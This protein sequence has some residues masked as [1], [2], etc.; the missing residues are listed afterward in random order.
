MRRDTAGVVGRRDLAE[1]IAAHLLDDV[2]AASQVLRQPAD[3][4]GD[5]VV[6]GLRALAAA[7]HQQPQPA[8]R[9]GQGIGPAADG[10]DR[11]AYRVADDRRLGAVGGGKALDLGEAGGDGLGPGGQEPVG[12]AEHRVLLVQHHAQAGQAAGQGC[13]HGGIAAEADDRVG[14]E[15]L[16][17][18]AGLHEPDRQAEQSLE[19]LERTAAGDAA[20]ADPMDRHLAQVRAEACAAPVGDELH[21]AAAGEKLA[22]QG[23]GGEHVPARAPR[24]QHHLGRPGRAHT[25]PPEPTR[26]R[27]RPSTMPMASETASS[28]EPP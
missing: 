14:A 15:A 6:E 25:S 13:R 20:G 19:P 18:A 11:R 17:Q 21:L 28:E 5:H 8:I 22:G 26:R 10:E 12:P 1:R 9:P 23:L 4:L 27:V 2:Q 24:G 16:Q 3:G 7:G